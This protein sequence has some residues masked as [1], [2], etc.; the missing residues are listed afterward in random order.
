MTQRRYGPGQ[1]HPDRSSLDPQMPGDGGS[2]EIKEDPQRD[3][4]TLPGRQP[5]YCREQGGIEA[6][7]KVTGSHQVVVSQGHFA[8]PPPPP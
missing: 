6:T 2:V 1:V 5:P 7:V 3:H 8:A 4:L